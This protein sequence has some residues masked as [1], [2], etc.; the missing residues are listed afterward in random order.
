MSFSLRHQNCQQYLNPNVFSKWDAPKTH[1]Q[2]NIQCINT[3]NTNR[4]IWIASKFY[5]NNR[6]AKFHFYFIFFCFLYFLAFFHIIGVFNMFILIVRNF[7]S[8]WKK[9]LRV[10]FFFLCSCVV[11]TFKLYSNGKSVNYLLVIV[12]PY[13]LKILKES[14]YGSSVCFARYFLLLLLF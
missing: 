12:F 13:V 11:C 3:I 2:N 8:V 6:A 4:K 9:R 7:L 1:N 5:R 14:L 10:L